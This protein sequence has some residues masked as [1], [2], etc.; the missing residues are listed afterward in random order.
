MW[1]P[2]GLEAS[3]IIAASPEDAR[4]P[5]GQ[6][7]RVVVVEGRRRQLRDAGGDGAHAGASAPRRAQF[8]G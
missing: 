7:L 1:T 8:G 2:D 4:R 5:S 3:P 6:P